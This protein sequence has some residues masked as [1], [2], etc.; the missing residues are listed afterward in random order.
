LPMNATVAGPYPFEAG[1]DV[2]FVVN[3]EEAE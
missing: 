3:R 2:F 1:V